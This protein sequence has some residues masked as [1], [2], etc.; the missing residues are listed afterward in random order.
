MITFFFRVI[1]KVTINAREKVLKESAKLDEEQASLRARLIKTE[2]GVDKAADVALD[3]DRKN[4]GTFES[5][6]GEEFVKDA[7]F[8]KS[9]RRDLKTLGTEVKEGEETSNA[10]LHELSDKTKSG[11]QGITQDTDKARRAATEDLE[12]MQ[13]DFEKKESGMES[14]GKTAA[15]D[16]EDEFK[17]NLAQQERSAS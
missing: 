4:L 7:D 12:R 9:M 16:A 10:R 13:S 17:H 5:L 8:A 2:Q 14:E 15:T 3:K 1:N 6:A 11:F